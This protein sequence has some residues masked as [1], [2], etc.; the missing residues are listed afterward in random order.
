V[1]VGP[2][3]LSVLDGVGGGLLE[4]L[5]GLVVVLGAAARHH[6]AQELHGVQLP[7]GVLGPRVIHQAD[8]H[9]HTHTQTKR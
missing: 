2:L 9:T 3:Y 1:R 8:L 6:V 7:V 5:D 4:Q